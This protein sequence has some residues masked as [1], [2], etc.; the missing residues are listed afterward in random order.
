[1]ADVINTR[2]K[3]RVVIEF[4]TAEK[5]IPIEIHRRLNSGYGEHTADV[6]TV[7]HWLKIMAWHKPCSRMK[8]ILLVDFL[9]KGIKVN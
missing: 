6:S 2:L 9:E 1:M 7:R 5:V 4:F 8:G 3:H